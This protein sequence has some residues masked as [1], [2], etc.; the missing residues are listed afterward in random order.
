VNIPVS[1]VTPIEA[2]IA[3]ADARKYLVVLAV[4]RLCKSYG[5]TT[6]F[7]GVTFSV[8]HNEIVGLVGPNGAGK[9]T[10]INII[11]GVLEPSSGPVF[12][13]GVN[14]GTNRSRAL[15][16]TNFAAVYAPLPG[17]LTVYQNLRAVVAGEQ[18]STVALASASFLTLLY[19]LLAA[20]YFTRSYRYAVRTGLLARYSAE[21]AA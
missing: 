18:V 9:T 6:A 3:A 8:E 13:D 7:D 14:I 10:T 11:L 4:D 15:Q 19:L 2:P 12:I 1:I 5:A 21:N 16:H 20:W 17:N